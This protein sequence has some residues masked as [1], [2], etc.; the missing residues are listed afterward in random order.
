MGTVLRVTPE[1]AQTN[2]NWSQLRL[3]S[4]R[5][6]ERWEKKEMRGSGIWQ[7]NPAAPSSPWRDLHAGRGPVPTSYPHLALPQ[8]GGNSQHPHGREE[9]CGPQ[10]PLPCP[11]RVWLCNLHQV[12]KLS[13]LQR[14][15]TL[16]GLLHSSRLLLLSSIS[17][18][19]P[20]H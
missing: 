12:T 16:N 10:H 20:Y 14:C 17:F 4:L 18:F 8:R 1:T 9:A 2:G 5:G 6:Y 7:M 13:S 15:S 11:A 3:S 19:S